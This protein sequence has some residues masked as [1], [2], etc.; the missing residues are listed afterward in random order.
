M[1]AINFIKELKKLQ[2]PVITLNDVS[3]II[4]KNK[5]YS[6][7]YVHRL[8]KKKLIHEIEKGKYTLANNPFEIASGMLFP[9][10]ISF[11]S[12]YGIY[13]L[14]TQI[15]SIIHVVATK[16]RKPIKI[17]NTKINFIR[18]KKKNF[19]GYKREKFMD[20]YI[21]VAEPEKA[22]ID[23]LYLPK[24]CPVSESYEALKSK[25]LSIDKLVDYAL[26]IQSCVVL[27]RLGYLLE[28]NNINIY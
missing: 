27:K 28:L 25:E 26:R 13:G 10:Y 4:N 20:T 9:S 15:P 21:F 23:S 5:E 24:Y 12:A 8:K 2:N 7:V 18:I 17:D 6:R 3:R 19:F 16:S 11:I 14:T 1:Q 22:V